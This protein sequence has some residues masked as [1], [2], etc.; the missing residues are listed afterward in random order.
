[1]KM[2]WHH[3]L[4]VVAVLGAQL[5]ASDW[6]FAQ[7]RRQLVY[8]SF[9]S[10]QA[11]DSKG[12]QAFLDKLNGELG[13]VQFRS[14]FG[15]SMGGPKEILT[16]ISTGVLQSGQGIDGYIPREFAANSIFRSLG[17]LGENPLVVTGAINE[18][19]LLSCARCQQDMDN[20][21]VMALASYSTSDYLLLCR[22]P[23]E[24]AAN[25][26]SKRVR[27]VGEY[28]QVIKS[29]G[30]TPVQI[31]FPETYEALQRG[32]VECS[33]SQASYLR[34]LNFWDVAK[35]VY[36]TPLGTYNTA[37]LLAINRDVWKGLTPQDRALIKSGLAAATADVV[38]RSIEEE[39]DIRAQAP[40]KGVKFAPLPADL[41]A[42]LAQWRAPAN[43]STVVAEAGQR[44]GVT[45]AQQLAAVYREKLEKW[46][47]LLPEISKGREAYAAALNREIFSKAAF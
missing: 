42:K 34:A 20:F 27:S 28:A 39:N 40:A 3:T 10:P 24:S 5:I 21:K 47:K 23:I 44:Y 9:A 33:H 16:N 17:I 38:Y 7:E 4:L 6:T 13:S 11:P 29:M 32:Q 36:D 43:I 22:N 1:M 35:Y 15:G 12:T 19:I 37:Q 8:G 31:P 46:R 18:T 14:A 2:K 26:A 41:Q 30:A 25:F 45:D